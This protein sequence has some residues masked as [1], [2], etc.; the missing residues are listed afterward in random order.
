MVYVIWFIMVLVTKETKP[1]LK[2]SAVNII[3][4]D[5]IYVM[6]IIFKTYIRLF[7]YYLR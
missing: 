4:I 3:T 7:L 5:T 2:L 6:D 1:M